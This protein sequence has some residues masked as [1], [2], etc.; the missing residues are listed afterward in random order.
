MD[1]L[2]FEYHDLYFDEPLSTEDT[3]MLDLAA[4]SYPEPESEEILLKLHNRLNDNLTII[5]ALYRFYYYQHRYQDTLD[6]AEK[7]LKVSAV[8]LRLRVDWTELTE[9]HL[10]MCVFVSMGLIRF[11]MLGLK[12]SA[13]VLMRMERIEEAHARLKKIVELDPAD[14]FGSSFLLKIAERRLSTEHA[15]Q[16]NVESVCNRI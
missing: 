10:G 7:A 15:R 1:F 2:D 8:K 5:V 9:D 13:Y 4:E 16:H 6:I 12:A 11:Y 14:Q 3:A